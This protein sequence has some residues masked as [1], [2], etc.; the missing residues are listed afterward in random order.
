MD[1]LKLV[2]LDDDPQG[3]RVLE[4]IIGDSY[5]LKIVF[6]TT[7]PLLALD[8]L[9]ANSVDALIT[10]IVMD[11]MHGIHLASLVEKLDIPVII[12]SA[13]KDYA[14][15]SYQVNAVDFIYKPAEPAKFFKAIGKLQSSPQSA[16]ALDEN[17]LSNLLAINE[18]GSASMTLIRWDD[19]QY[20]R[21][22]GNYLEIC[23][24][25]RVYI[26]LIS[27]T[28]IMEKLPA[29]MFYRVHRS[30]TINLKKIVKLKADTI[31]LEGG[32]EVPLGS[33]Y[34]EGFYSIFRKLSINSPRRRENKT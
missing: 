21:V 27:L 19:I 9:R 1:I 29:S 33:S 28:A 13:Y 16:K 34:Y 5:F 30:Y 8:F 11:K 25:I 6:S 2:L 26:V 23:T 20:I 15:D 7:D 10:D 22:D 31:Y 14:Y 24:S 18:H 4:K 12:C 32:H 3:L 17:Y